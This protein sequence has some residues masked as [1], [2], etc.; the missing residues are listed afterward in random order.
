MASINVA[1][2]TGILERDPRTKFE[3]D[4]A[5]MTSFTLRYEESR[6]DGTTFKLYIP[7]ECYGRVAE[8][9]A[10]LGAGDVVGVEGR[11][12]WRSYRERDGQK[13]GTLAVMARQVTVFLPAA[14]PAE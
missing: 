10:T 1:C 2:V 4:G 12:Q 11:W 8:Q 9:T 6:R 13:Q 7:V 14:T 3:G 5:Q